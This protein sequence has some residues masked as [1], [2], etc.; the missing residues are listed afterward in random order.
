MYAVQVIINRLVAEIVDF[1][2]SPTFLFLEILVGIYTAIVF[3]D[4]VLLVI[5]RQP[6]ANWRKMRYGV[7]IP[8]EFVTGKKSM[9]AKWSKIKKRLESDNSAEYKV[10]IIEADDI[11]DDL[12][13]RLGYGGENMGDRLANIPEGQIENVSEIKEAHEI[14]NRIIH[15]EDFEVSKELAQEVLGKFEHLLDHFEVLG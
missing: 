11:I 14:R 4:I 6:L 5:Q 7:D 9:K 15:E 10:A 3:I 12:I 13:K 1:Y 2:H 8:K